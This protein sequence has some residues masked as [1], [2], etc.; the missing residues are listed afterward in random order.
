MAANSYYNAPGEHHLYPSPLSDQFSQ[1]PTPLRPL[2]THT[3]YQQVGALE[4]QDDLNHALQEDAHLKARIRRF[5]VI[6][7]TLSTLISIGV[8][9]P[10][11]MTV[12]KFLQTQNTYRDVTRPDGTTVTRTAWA[13]ES[14]VW[15]TYS[16]FGVALASTLLNLATIFSYRASVSRAN[17][18]AIATTTFSWA[19]M[20]GNVVVW[21]VAAS[22]YRKEKDRGGKSDDLWGWTC[23]A[24]ARLVQKEFAGEVDFNRYC[25]VQSASWYIGL[26]QVGAGVLTVGIYVMV[27]VRRKSKRRVQELSIGV[28]R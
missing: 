9:T 6:S 22:V 16:Y 24:A 20:L 12:A 15:P 21:A 14:R 3:G 2:F 23:S 10:I 25:D 18:V 11:A 1:P 13:H 26:A 17:S 7:R 27:F 8:L 28:A 5:R 19:V 4:K